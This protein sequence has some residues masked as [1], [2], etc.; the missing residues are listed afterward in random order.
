MI[1]IEE[2]RCAGFLVIIF[3]ARIEY[4]DS[5]FLSRLGLARGYPI[6]KGVS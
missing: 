1:V 2:N 5:H 6:T 4:L 3:I